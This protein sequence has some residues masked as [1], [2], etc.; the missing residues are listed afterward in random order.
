M[1]RTR[2]STLVT[3][4]CI[5]VAA[6][7]CGDGGGR[8]GAVEG[9]GSD[10]TRPCSPDGQPALVAYNRKTGGV[11]WAVCASDNVRR[12]VLHTTADRVYVTEYH[13]GAPRRSALTT[14]R[15]ASWSRGPRTHP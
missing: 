14:R 12:N 1:L 11:K 13:G 7:A 2:V 5:A 3:V 6:T 4:L 15:P 8:A 10:T 9:A